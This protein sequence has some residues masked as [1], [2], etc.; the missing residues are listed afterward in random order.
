MG[1]V[2]KL[3]NY[4]FLSIYRLCYEHV[5]QCTYMFKDIRCSYLVHFMDKVLLFNQTLRQQKWM[6]YFRNKHKEG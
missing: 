6:V 3:W 4:T 5:A 2:Y 1:V